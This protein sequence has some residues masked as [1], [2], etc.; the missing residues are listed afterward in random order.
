MSDKNEKQ[1]PKNELPQPPTIELPKLEA[2]QDLDLLNEEIPAPP[3]D[4][5]LEEEEKKQD[6]GRIEGEFESQSKTEEKPEIVSEENF[7]IPETEFKKPL[8]SNER[9]H[10]QMVLK[11]NREAIKDLRKQV[12][13]GLV[14][15]DALTA[16]LETKELEG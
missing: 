8:D 6:E 16:E 4:A 10:Y 1:K 15:I 14:K 13:I 9:K 5:F 7:E 11:A 2:E 3:L 12:Q